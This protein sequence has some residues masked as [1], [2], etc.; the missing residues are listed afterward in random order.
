MSKMAMMY[1]NEIKKLDK[2][3]RVAIPAL[4]RAELGN[5]FIL[6]I[7]E[8][9]CLRAYPYDKWNEFIAIIERNGLEE[10][11]FDSILAN[12]RPITFDAQGRITV[13]DSLKKQRGIEIE[14]AI[15]GAGS[16]MEIWNATTW[17]EKDKKASSTDSVG[18]LMKKVREAK[19]AEQ[20]ARSKTNEQ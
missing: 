18:G 14:I 17:Q 20:S 10:E 19:K 11:G 2:T 7:S 9:D 16:Y 3:G 6:T 15:I 4:H 13:P 8:K 1:G 12:A 5:E